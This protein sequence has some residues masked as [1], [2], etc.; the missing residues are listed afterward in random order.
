MT[1]SDSTV[2]HH[3]E[4]TA[5]WSN[6]LWTQATVFVMLSD[7]A[8]TNV[9]SAYSRGA[10]ISISLFYNRYICSMKQLFN[11]HVFST[12]YSD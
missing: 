2:G 6:A 4:P 3:V 8:I 1:R 12:I 9:Y 7:L 5:Q 10:Q 11:Q